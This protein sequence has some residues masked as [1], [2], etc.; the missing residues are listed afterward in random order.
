MKWEHLG[1]RGVRARRGDRLEGA[2]H[3]V[4]SGEGVPAQIGAGELEL[5]VEEPAAAAAVGVAGREPRHAT[6]APA[7]VVP[8]G[9]VLPHGASPEDH[10]LLGFTGGAT[11]ELDAPVGEE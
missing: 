8:V 7:G 5:E 1:H 10:R 6:D 4:L 11:E 9:A 2:D 3:G